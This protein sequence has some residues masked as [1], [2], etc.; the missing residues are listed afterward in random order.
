MDFALDAQAG[1]ITARQT[2]SEPVEVE[3]LAWD[4]P[5]ESLLLLQEGEVV[6]LRIDN[7]PVHDYTD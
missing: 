5:G 6:T 2:L 4:V 1:T 3:L 7:E